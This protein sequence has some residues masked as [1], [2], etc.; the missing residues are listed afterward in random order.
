MPLDPL[1]NS[2]RKA[3]R[4]LGGSEYAL[5]WQEP[6]VYSRQADW[7][8]FVE[9]KAFF[10]KAILI[11]A[12]LISV[13][14]YAGSR[15]LGVAIALFAGTVVCLCLLLGLTIAAIVNRP[16]YI[17]F[18]ES[19]IIHSAWYFMNQRWAYEDVALDVAEDQV[20]SDS[21]SILLI[22]HRTEGRHSFALP[23]GLSGGEFR[24]RISGL[25]SEAA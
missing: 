20:G 24:E 9:E 7:R 13:A 22:D 19:G 25:A 6:L 3:S 23:S 2:L 1:R 21:Y 10:W 17:A 15:S 11:V 12:M 16:R 14:V 4:Q 18:A 8:A 5:C